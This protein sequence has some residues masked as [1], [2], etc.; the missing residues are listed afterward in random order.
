MIL[1]HFNP[2]GIN[3][4]GNVNPPKKMQMKYTNID[5]LWEDLGSSHTL[6]I[7]IPIK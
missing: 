3:S 1:L 7:N 5:T 2:E 4:I 6:P